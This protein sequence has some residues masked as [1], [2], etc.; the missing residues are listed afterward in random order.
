MRTLDGRPAIVTGAGQGVGRGI[1]LAL[2]NAGAPVAVLG[3]TETTLEDTCSEINRRGGHAIAV[4]CDVRERDEIDRAVQT[5]ADELGGIKILVNNAQIFPYGT[6]RELEDTVIDDGWRSGPLA[7]LRL[8]QACYAYLEGGGAVINVSSGAPALAG[9][10]GLAGYAAVKAAL[11]TFSRAA[12]VEWGT[13]GVRVN[14]I[15]PMASSPAFDEWEKNDPET[16][17][18]VLD[19][20]PMRKLCDPVDDIGRAVVFLV[21][22]DAKMITGVS[23]PI[24]GGGLYLR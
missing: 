9:P 24:D 13:A 12:A 15:M 6:I 21:S 7:A 19:Q 3:R 5:V 20:I 11:Q 4:K 2:A 1:A 17:S 14:T 23:L 18:T 16:F 8:M 10:P 22:E